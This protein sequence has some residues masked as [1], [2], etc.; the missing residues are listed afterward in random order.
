MNRLWRWLTANTNANAIAITAIA[1][2]VQ[3]ASLVAAVIGLYLAWIQI[4]S[5]KDAL[6]GTLTLQLQKDGRDLFGAME[7]LVREYIYG[8]SPTETYKDEISGNARQRI[9]QVLNY[10]ASAYRQ[11]TKD[12]IDA[13]VWLSMQTEMC[14]FLKHVPVR[15]VW[16]QAMQL[17]IYPEKFR[18][19][20]QQCLTET[21]K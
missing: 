13:E 12:R 16:E 21:S 7:P 17:K 19:I 15:R 14:S 1:S 2:C 18:E 8:Y 9:I 4:D 11:Y 6:K 5:A 20:G 10:Y 3:A